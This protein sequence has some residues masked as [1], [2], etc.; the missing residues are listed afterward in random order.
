LEESLMM[1][2]RVINGYHVEKLPISMMMTPAI[3]IL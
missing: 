3:L 2:Y 1:L